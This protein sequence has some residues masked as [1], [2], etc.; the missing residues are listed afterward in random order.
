MTNKL[1]DNHVVGQTKDVGFQIGARKT[2][3]ISPAQAWDVITSDAGIETWLGAV[4]NFELKEGAVY[5]TDDGAVGEIRVVKPGGHF[6]MTWQPPDWERPSLIQV[7]VIPSGAKAV[8][9]FHQ[10]HLAGP[11]ER[12]AMRRR[13]QKV[14]KAL[15]TLFDQ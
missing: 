12:E 15:P 6:R 8:I 13:W 7:R 3:D 1:D 14:L 10:E 11:K 9:S 4:S 5:Q 2:F